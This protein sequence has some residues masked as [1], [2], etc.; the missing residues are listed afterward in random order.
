MAID[1]ASTSEMT[2]LFVAVFA[3]TGLLAASASATESTIVPGVGIGK[4]KLG[5]TQAQVEKVLGKDHLVNARATVGGSAYRELAWNFST[6]SVGFLRQGTT[7]RAVQV[8]T[9]LS[10]QR[11]LAGIGVSS[12]F[13]QVV[14]E[15]SQVF[16]GGIYSTFGPGYD[17]FGETSLILVNK[18]PVYTAFAVKPVTPNDYNG[19]WRVYAVIVQQSVP[20]HVSLA[21]TR[22]GDKTVLYHCK[23]GWRERGTPF[24]FP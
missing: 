20:G 6:W 23:D 15:Y 22:E 19:A 18:G 21:R 14:R 5:M 2:R 9:T 1:A 12:P 4:V 24:T 17:R 11:T 3:V 8:E 7:W 13:K 16:C 10:P